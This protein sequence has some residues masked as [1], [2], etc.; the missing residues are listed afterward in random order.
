MNTKNYIY[1]GEKFTLEISDNCIIT[2]SKDGIKAT[3]SANEK[4]GQF[5]VSANDSIISMNYP[6]E[7]SAL[8]HACGRVLDQT[9][10]KSKE[11][12]CS[13]LEDLFKNIKD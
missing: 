5:L 12:L 4:T 2:V 10:A 3:I 13:R 9:K 7:K 11:E 6:D 8:D 1:N